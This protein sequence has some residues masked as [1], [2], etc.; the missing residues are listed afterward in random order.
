MAGPQHPFIVVEQFI[1]QFLSQ[2][3]IGLQP[4][5]KLHTE[6]GCAI[7]IDYK[8]TTSVPSAEVD[9]RE[10]KK[11]SGRGSRKRRKNQRCSLQGDS[12]L[13]DTLTQEI[14]S[15][16][17]EPV[18]S[19]DID[20]TVSVESSLPTLSV[21]HHQD[22]DKE[23]VIN[24]HVPDVTFQTTFDKPQESSSEP[25]LPSPPDTFKPPVMR[26]VSEEEI[27]RIL[28]SCGMKTTHELDH[29]SNPLL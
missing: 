8:V 15:D 13:Q 5:L 24:Q 12:T 28:R 27:N 19:T 7:T 10:V 16:I 20:D 17:A 9:H 4:S 22:L 2:W 26:I 18:V 25:L 14:S 21:Q 1:H 23:P 3:N 11:K 6:P 29:E